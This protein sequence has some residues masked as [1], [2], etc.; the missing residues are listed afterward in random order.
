MTA[1]PFDVFAFTHSLVESGIPNN[2]AE[3]IAKAFT[4]AIQESN[5]SKEITL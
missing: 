4:S 2:Q 3:S 1:I 5:A